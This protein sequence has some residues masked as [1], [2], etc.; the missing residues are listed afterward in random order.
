MLKKKATFMGK[1]SPYADLKSTYIVQCTVLPLLY[2]NG[3][4]KYIDKQLC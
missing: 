2:G 1:K 3:V 4:K